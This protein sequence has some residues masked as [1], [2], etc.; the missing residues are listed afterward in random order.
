MQ[1]LFS[2][3]SRLA[4]LL[5]VR[6]PRPPAGILVDTRGQPPRHRHVSGPTDQLV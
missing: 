2:A 1:A 4:V 3:H 5:L 6:T